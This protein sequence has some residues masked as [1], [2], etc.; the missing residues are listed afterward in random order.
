MATVQSILRSTIKP[1][2]VRSGFQQKGNWFARPFEHGF[3]L[4]ELQSNQFPPTGYSKVTFNLGV[5]WTR[6][7]E[8]M[9]RPVSGFHFSDDHHTVFRRL[10]E[11]MPQRRDHWWQLTPEIASGSGREKIRAVLE[12]T[13]LPW[14]ER[15]HRI[16]QSIALASEYSLTEFIAALERVKTE[17]GETRRGKSDAALKSP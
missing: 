12:K 8:L 7:E 9:G 5:C 3:D 16:D 4:L 1:L 17:L 15:A 6:A 13:A 10:G 2:L 14:F 11:I